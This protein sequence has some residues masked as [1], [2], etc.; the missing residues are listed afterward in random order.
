MKS[1][2]NSFNEYSYYI[3]PSDMIEFQYCKRFIYYM[4]V[5]GIQQFEEK[6]YKVQKGRRIHEKKEGQNKSYLRKKLGVKNKYIDVQLVSERLK[7]RGKVDEVLLL[8]DDTMAPLDYKF[9]IFDEKVYN[10]YK[11]QMIMYALMVKEVFQKEVEKAFLV[12]C[13]GNN[14]VK[15]LSINKQDENT[16][17]EEIQEYEKVLQGYYPKATR[18]K[19]RCDDCCYK[20]ICIK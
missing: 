2:Q 1:F 16:I 12:Y 15:E 3:T 13:R 11:M 9:A 17:V 7:I 4:K 6:R 14:S 8:H 10:T 18:Y 19:S 5:L 20:N